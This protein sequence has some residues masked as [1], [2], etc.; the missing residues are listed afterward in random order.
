MNGIPSREH[1]DQRR[2]VLDQ[3]P[4]FLGAKDSAVFVFLNRE[5]EAGTLPDHR[6]KEFVSGR[7]CRCRALSIRC[8]ACIACRRRSE[9]RDMVVCTVSLELRSSIRKRDVA[10]TSPF[11]AIIIL[12]LQA[13]KSGA[14]CGQATTAIARNKNMLRRTRVRR[15]ISLP[16]S[17][18][19]SS[20]L[21]DAGG[22]RRARTLSGTRN[23]V[24]ARTEFRAG[25]PIL[26]ASL[27]KRT[28]LPYW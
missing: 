15:S 25:S 20:L 6:G 28:C 17:P 2:T 16:R 10:I 22:F 1:Q 12:L 21:R 5:N 19:R 3:R 18:I 24:S 11:A 4:C 14:F 7:T 26:P 8:E 27:A 23:R 13:E 9:P